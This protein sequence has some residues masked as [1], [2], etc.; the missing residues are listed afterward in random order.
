VY[1]VYDN[2]TPGREGAVKLASALFNVTKYVYICNIGEY[3]KE[4]KEDITDFFVKYKLGTTE[5]NDMMSKAKQFDSTCQEE[6]VKKSYPEVTLNEASTT[7]LG[8]IVRSNVQVMATYEDQYSVPSYA[9]FEKV[10]VG[11]KE[12][13]NMHHKGDAEYWN[14][15]KRNFEDVLIL[16]DN[17]LKKGQIIDNLKSIVGWGNE[18]FVEVKT[19]NPKTIFKACVADCTESVVAKDIKRTEFTCYTDE[20]LEAGKNYQIIY[21]VVPHPYKGQQQVQQERELHQ[22]E[23][24]P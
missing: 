12:E 8:K 6:Y 2:D 19:S 22:G 17:N 16:T 14:L 13:R 10:S 11:G 20:K 23:R 21:K 5:F 18:D 15:Q 9:S 24:C 1:I 4:D 7:Y 3:V